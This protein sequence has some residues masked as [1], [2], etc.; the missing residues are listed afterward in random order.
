[1]ASTTS[2]PVAPLDLSKAA[3]QF[4]S[5]CEARGPPPPLPEEEA[6]KEEADKEEDD[7]EEDDC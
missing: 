3:V 2:P 4:P 5:W 7:K 6:D 1:M